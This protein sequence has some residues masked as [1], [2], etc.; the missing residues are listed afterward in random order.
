MAM[1]LVTNLFMFIG[2]TVLLWWGTGLVVESIS[3]VARSLRLS[4]FTLAFF[5]L[6]IMTSLPETMIGIT[7]IS[8]GE[9]PIMVGNLIGGSLIMFLLVIPLLAL[10][11]NQ[12]S[13]PSAMRRPELSLTLLTILA[14]ALLIAD[15]SLHVWEGFLL[16]G[17]YL[18]LFI[19]L[20]RK[21]SVY[22]KI[23][24]RLTQTTKH[25]SKHRILKITFGV[26]IIILAAQL[27]VSVAE[28][29]AV[30][31]GW[32]PFVVGLVI[33]AFGTNI[34]EL[35]LVL[36][37]RLSRK[38]DVALAD[39]IGSATANTLLIGVFTLATGG[40]IRLPNHALVRIILLATSLIL[41]Y[42]FI[43]SSGRLSRR[44]SLVLLFIYVIFVL[45][46]INNS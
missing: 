35:T 19:I 12:V 9:A 39:Y 33:V 34:P 14:P 31:F 29:A 1:A 17:L 4:A 2:A 10:T 38:A 15:R 5:V 28:Y 27:M 24:H 8:R 32:S 37:A 23:V 41:F 16:L 26:G 45:L 20:S 18:T 22:E 7:A 21:E 43:R 36:R 42:I 25:K 6:G 11:G 13:L 30:A 46:E 44:E 40:T 3:S